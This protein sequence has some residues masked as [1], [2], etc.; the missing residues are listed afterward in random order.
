M[1][2]RGV[3]ALAAAAG[4]PEPGAAGRGAESAPAA[5]LDLALRLLALL[6]SQQAP[7]EDSSQER[8]QVAPAGL[9]SLLRDWLPAP[10]GAGVRPP[11]AAELAAA[12]VGQPALL[13]V[14]WS[15]L[16]HLAAY[17]TLPQVGCGRWVVGGGWWAVGG[18][19]QC[20]S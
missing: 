13:C 17:G 20:D 1:L 19:L 4:A 11:A 15:S 10:G 6:G 5:A 16:A 9:E 8:A 7:A 12:L 18:W 14:L 2:R 3:S